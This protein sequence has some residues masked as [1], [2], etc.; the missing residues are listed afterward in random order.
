MEGTVRRSVTDPEILFL[1]GYGM[2]V[3]IYGFYQ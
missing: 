3:S 1:G 2:S